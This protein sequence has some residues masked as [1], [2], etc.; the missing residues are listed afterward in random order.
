MNLTQDVDRERIAPSPPTQTGRADLPHPA[1]RFVATDERAQA[2]D[3]R[4]GTS[5]RS[6]AGFRPAGL[7]VRRFTVDP[8]VPRKPGFP[9]RLGAQPCGTTQT[10]VGCMLPIDPH[11]VPTPLRSTVVTRFFATTRALTPTGPLATGR[12]SLI[13]VIWT[14]DHSVSNHLRFS[15]SRVHFLCAVSSMAF[16][17]RLSLAGSSEPP[18]ESSS[19]ALRT[20]HSLPVA[21]HPGIS[22]RRSYFQL[23]A[24]QCW[25]GRGLSPRCPNAL[26]GALGPARRAGR[27]GT[28]RLGEA[29]LPL[30]STLSLATQNL[31]DEF[32]PLPADA[33]RFHGYLEELLRQ[34]YLHLAAQALNG[35]L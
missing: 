18:T 8:T 34:A 19:L 12:G 17:L 25:L 23:L 7:I 24:F 14:S 2:L 35:S 6:R 31:E 32:T 10:L 15:G 16:G 1:F 11:H 28:G 13:Y 22:P 27:G 5:R 26:S 4:L 21:L 29:S 30:S 9:A 33:L 20:S 3:S